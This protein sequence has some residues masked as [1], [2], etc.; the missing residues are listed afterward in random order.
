MKTFIRTLIVILSLTVLI[1][2]RA[3]DTADLFLKAYFLIQDGDASEK[4]DDRAKAAEKYADAYKILRQ[5]QKNDSEWNPNIIA[6]RTKYAGEHVVKN[7]GKI[8]TDEEIAASVPQPAETPAPS[9]PAT[10]TPPSAPEP[11]APV[12]AKVDETPKTSFPAGTDSVS[13]SRIAALEKELEDTRVELKKIQQDK[14]DLEARLKKAEDDLKMAGS[15]GDER[16]QALLQENNKLKQNLSDAETKLKGL[17]SSTGD[18]ASLR[19][20]LEQAQKSIENL[21]KE[22]EDLRAANDSL[23]RDLEDTRAQLKMGGGSSAPLSPEAL[24]TLQKENALLRN[25]VERHFQEDSRRAAARDI[26]TAELKELGT[27]TDSIRAQL[28]VLKTPLSPLSDDERNLLKM[29]GAASIRSTSE[30][31]NKLSGVVTAAKRN[32]PA[33]STKLSGDNAVLASDAKRL[34]SKGDLN[35]AAAKYEM[36]IK[37]DPRNIFALSNLGVIRFR[38][39]R[40]PEAEKALR[41]ALALDPQ[42]AF[43]LSVLGIVHYKNNKYDEAISTLTRAISINP[44]NP[45]THNYLGIT[46]SQ[47]GYQEAAEKELM[48]ALELQPDYPDAHFNLAVV[49]TSQTPPSTELAKK[50][51]KKAVELGIAKDSEFEKLLNKS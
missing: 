44:N 33:E 27:R 45:E 40:I 11:A 17:P 31:P 41:Q 14:V 20:E 6:Y 10:A 49:L 47:K 29:S 30:D 8:P 43:S 46:Y 36:I 16:V 26:L 21:K 25:I 13:A 38:Q 7:G 28:E 5:I 22:N 1:S 37:N 35:G 39:E 3:V 23:K 32:A 15:G 51:Y 19:A 42:D 50:H 2:A 4:G 24:Q 9:A 48:K 34:F 12:A 18:I